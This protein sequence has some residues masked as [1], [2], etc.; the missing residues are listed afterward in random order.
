MDENELKE[1]NK[2]RR[3]KLAGFFLNLAQISFTVLAIGLP[4]TL[5]KEELYDNYMLIISSVVGFILTIVFAKIGN[6]ILK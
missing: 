3:E 4:V 6:N 2:V 5:F 1:R